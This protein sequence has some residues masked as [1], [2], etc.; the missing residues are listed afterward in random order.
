MAI[1]FKGVLFD[2]FVYLGVQR[3]DVDDAVA[4]DDVWRTTAAGKGRDDE[5]ETERTEV[6]EMTNAGSKRHFVMGVGVD[7]EVVAPNVILNG[8]NR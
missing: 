2:E 7:C 4:L 6:N 3:A 5:K 1:A 8:L